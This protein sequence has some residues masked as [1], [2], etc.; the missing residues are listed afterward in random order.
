MR[1]KSRR[2]MEAPEAKAVLLPIV[3]AKLTPMSLRA[4]ALAFLLAFLSP[5][6]AQKVNKPVSRDLRVFFIDV[7][8]GQATLFVTPAGKSLLVDTGWGGN[9]FRDADRIAATARRAG[10]TK[11]DYVLITHFHAD[12]VGGVPQLVQRIPVGTFIDHGINREL[13]P[14]VTKLYMDY[15]Q[16]L[17]DHGYEHLIARPG[18]MLP[19]KEM[20][21]RVISADGDLI[22]APLRGAGKPNELCNTPVD[23]PA[24]KTENARS[25]GILVTFGKL[26]L[27][28]LGDLTADKEVELMCRS[29]LLGYVDV[30][31]VS[32]H[33]WEQSS[34][35]LFVHSV[36]PRVAIMDNGEKKGGSVAVLDTIRSSPGLQDLWQLHYSAEGGESHNTAASRI[37]N[38]LGKDEGNGIELD[39]LKDGSFRVTNERT[40]ETKSY[41]RP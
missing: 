16:V 11:I 18:Q 27:L 29:N 6:A 12:H 8:G 20:E 32:H 37:A 26:T 30:L 2:F 41:A 15:Q 36:Q 38:L 22:H 19:I 14:E 7:E 33:G 4:F 35:P 10:V 34:S 3:R 39:V 23:Y 9:N 28:D 24:D 25:L 1:V 31:I 40:G 21:A 17:A 13:T 5:L